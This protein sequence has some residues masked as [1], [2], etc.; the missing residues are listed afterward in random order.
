MKK[1]R[2]KLKYSEKLFLE[3]LDLPDDV[4]IT[5]VDFD[6]DRSMI[7]IY[8][9]GDLSTPFDPRREEVSTLQLAEVPESGETPEQQIIVWPSTPA[10]NCQRQHRRDK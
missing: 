7:L 5:G 6:P 4:V 3:K 2:A 10:L 8:V 9:A 1:G